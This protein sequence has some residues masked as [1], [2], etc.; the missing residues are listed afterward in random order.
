[1]QTQTEADVL[2]AARELV[3]HFAAHDTEN[4]FAAFAPEATF[5]FHTTPHPLNSREAYRA[6]WRDWEAGGF[7]ILDC[8]SSE[9][10]IRVHDD[11]AIFTHRVETRLIADGAEQTALERETIVFRRGNDG[12]WLAIHEHLSPCGFP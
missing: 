9:P 10:H 3:A 2:C 4:Y 8:R 11:I 5:I 1:M 6:L 7:R 12:R